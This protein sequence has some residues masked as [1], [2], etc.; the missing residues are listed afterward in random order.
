MDEISIITLQQEI[1]DLEQ[2]LAAK[3]RQLEESQNVFGVIAFCGSPLS[4][5]PNFTRRKK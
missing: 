4:Q 3:K 5:I 1:E 2:Q